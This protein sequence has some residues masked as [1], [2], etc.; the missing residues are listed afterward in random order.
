[1][2]ERKTGRENERETVSEREGEV[3]PKRIPKG[4]RPQPRLP[5]V[6]NAQ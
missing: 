5:F 2:E 3:S 4:G 1:V 6:E